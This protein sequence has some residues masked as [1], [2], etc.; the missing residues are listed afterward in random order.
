MS[1]WDERQVAQ[2]VREGVRLSWGP[3][4]SPVFTEALCHQS[5]GV[6]A[7]ED[8]TKSWLERRQEALT[9]A[10]H[11]AAE[12]GTG[13]MGNPA[14]AIRAVS[15]WQAGSVARITQD[16]QDAMALMMACSGAAMPADKDA[17]QDSDD[18]AAA[19]PVK[20]QIKPLPDA[21]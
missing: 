12:C 7:V 8:F 18:E 2:T 3:L 13:A 19:E 10:M 20:K 9:S 17:D 11:C 5:I 6:Q 14:S 16:M 15:E 1:K 21:A 4:S